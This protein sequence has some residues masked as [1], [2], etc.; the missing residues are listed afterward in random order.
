MSNR[1]SNPNN[2]RINLDRRG[3][4]KPGPG[5]RAPVESAEP[6][7]G[8]RVPTLPTSMDVVPDQEGDWHLPQPEDTTFT[9]DDVSEVIGVVERPP[10]AIDPLTRWRGR[11]RC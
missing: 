1:P 10:D 8:W 4:H 5:W 6:V 3:W 11:Q 9:S 7:T 2:R